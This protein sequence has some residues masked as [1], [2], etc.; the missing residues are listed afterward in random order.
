MMN[1]PHYYQQVG[2]QGRIVAWAIFNRITDR[3]IC[4]RKTDSG[5]IQSKSYKTRRSAREFVKGKRKKQSKKGARN[6]RVSKI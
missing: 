6:V 5:A 2:P 4:R 3:W 1:Y